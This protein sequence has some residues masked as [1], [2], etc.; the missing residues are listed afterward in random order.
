M[1][2]RKAFLF[3]QRAKVAV[4]M[5]KYKKAEKDMKKAMEIDDTNIE[6]R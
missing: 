3:Y 2:T 1:D 5:G 4:A 6:Y